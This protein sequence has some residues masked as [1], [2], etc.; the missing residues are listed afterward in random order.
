[1]SVDTHLLCGRLVFLTIL[2]L[3]LITARLGRGGGLITRRLV[4]LLI[5]LRLLGAWLNRGLF[6]SGLRLGLW[7][8]FDASRAA[9]S[10]IGVGRGGSRFRFSN[11]G[12]RVEGK[13]GLELLL[14]RTR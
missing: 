6:R 11:H 14:L 7:L 8:I 1:M 3:P 2:S 5:R 4:F 12:Y 10:R 13:E 9:R